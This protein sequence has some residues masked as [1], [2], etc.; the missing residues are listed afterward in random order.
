MSSSPSGFTQAFSNDGEKESRALNG[1]KHFSPEPHY[2]HDEMIDASPGLHPNNIHDSEDDVSIK[3]TLK[4]FLKS[5]M[6]RR[7]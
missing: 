3:P 1:S 4:N 2:I 7:M 6:K 5:K